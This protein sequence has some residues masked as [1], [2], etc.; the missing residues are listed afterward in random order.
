MLESFF[1]ILNGEKPDEIVWTGD[2]LYW[3]AGQTQASNAF[4]GLNSEE[5][6]LRFCNELGI[7]PYY[8]YEKFWLAKPEY[9]NVEVVTEL[10]GYQ[11]RRIFKTAVGQLEEHTCFTELTCSEGYTKHLVES[12]ED[13]KVLAYILKNRQLVP[14][15]IDDYNDRARLWR[16]YDGIPCIAL[17][18]SPLP[19]F[20]VEWAG[21]QNGIYLMYDCPELVENI[22][23]LFEEQEKPIL[24]AVCSVAPPL[25][26]FADNLTSE[27]FTSFFDR[28]MA[29]QYKRRLEKLH[30]AN[31]KCAI[32][33]DGTVKGLLPK[34]AGVGIDAIE[35][36]TPK[37]AGDME[38]EQ[39]RDVVENEDVVLWGGVPG[40]VFSYPYTWDDM[41][42][43]VERVLESWDG[44]PFVLG[45]A[46]QVPPDGD[47][48]MV[49]KISDLVKKWKG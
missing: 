14:D 4:R 39:M 38:V 24:D 15:C 46:D 43:R 18:R 17:P 16:S 23:D 33:L 9:K 2:I 47:I 10:N 6:Y 27:T 45:I 29:P 32:H 37:P 26:H 41:K 48:T 40:T 7:M 5:G 22:L 42:K 31:V 25:V 13:L 30:S 8:W 12:K 20:F 44:Q 36:L 34:L 35:A 11:R 19:A 21:V 49:K 1:K 3:I 28:H